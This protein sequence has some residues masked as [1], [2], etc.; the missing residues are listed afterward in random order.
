MQDN[1]RK[2]VKLLKALQNIT[3]TEIAEYLEIKRNSFYN[4]LNG[5]YELSN[6]KILRLIEILNTISEG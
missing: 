5:Y 1:Y 4:W 2:Q 3:Y 6:E